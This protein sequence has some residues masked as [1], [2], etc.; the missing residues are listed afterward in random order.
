MTNTTALITNEAQLLFIKMVLS[1]WQTQ[2]QRLTALFAKLSDD[3]LAQETAPGRNSGIYLLG[4]MTAVHDAMLPLLGFG[5]RLFPEL[6]ET[7][8]RNPDRS[9]LPAPATATLRQYWTDVSTALD[10]HTNTLP[11]DDWF[12]RHSAVSEEDFLTEPHRNKLNIMINRTN[13][14]STH[15]GQ[16]IYLVK[17]EEK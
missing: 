15:L 10:Q 5:D 17:K 1:N 4:H 8:I 6:E 16:L 11:A 9:G 2:N 12:T 13:H 14:L 7:F 3:E